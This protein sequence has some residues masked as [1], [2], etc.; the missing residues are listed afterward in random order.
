MTT[1]LI[2]APTATPA[3]WQASPP[4]PVVLEAENVSIYYGSFRAI[5]D[6]TLH[7]PPRLELPKLPWTVPAIRS[8]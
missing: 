5:K 3:E 7:V 1:N 2:T 6:I 8:T 4:E